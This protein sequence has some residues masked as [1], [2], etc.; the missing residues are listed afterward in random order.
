M[1]KNERFEKELDEHASLDDVKSDV[2][3]LRSDVADLVA[4]LAESGV[5]IAKSKATETSEAIN[6]AAH[7]AREHAEEA[8]EHV[9]VSVSK[10]PITYLALAF[11]AGA[12]MGRIMARR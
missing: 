2:A 10:R 4:G 8:H 7:A 9:R 3:M 1:P 12:I 11:G 5:A 6:H